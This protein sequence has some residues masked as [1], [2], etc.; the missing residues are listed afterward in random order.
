[1]DGSDCLMKTIYRSVVELHIYVIV[2]F[3]LFAAPPHPPFSAKKKERDSKKEVNVT[4]SLAFTH[5]VRS[6]CPSSH[7]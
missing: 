4:H 3:V 2:A 1:M 7:T 5:Q 6:E